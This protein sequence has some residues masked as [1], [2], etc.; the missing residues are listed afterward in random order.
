MAQLRP[1][2]QK[3]RRRVYNARLTADE[4][5]VCIWWGRIS[6]SFSPRICRPCPH[7]RVWIVYADA[8]TSPTYICTLRV[9][10]D[11]G[12]YGAYTAGTATV[13]GCAGGLDASIPPHLPHL[14]SGID[15]PRCFLG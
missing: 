7:Y 12:R 13:I 9:Q 5:A 10:G 1:L 2:Y 6:R 14:W 4:L 8:A 3:L 15:R 11:T